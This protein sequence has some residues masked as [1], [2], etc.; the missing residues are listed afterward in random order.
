MPALWIG[1]T[2]DPNLSER[3]QAHPQWI[4]TEKPEW[5][6]RWWVDPSHRGVT[7]E[8]IPEIFRQIIDWGFQAVKWDCLP[9]SLRVMDEF[10]HKF[11]DPT[12]SSEQA[13]RGVVKAGRATLGDER[14]MMSCSGN[15]YRDITFAAD[16][17]DGARIGGDVFS[18][19]DYRREA[20]ERAFQY[21]CFH[22][23]LF[24][25]DQ[26]NLVLRG[27]YNTVDQAISRVSFAALTGTPLTFGD[28]LPSLEPERVELLKRA[29]PPLALHP[30]DLGAGATQGSLVLVNATVAQRFETWNVID[31]FNTIGE[32]HLAQLDLWRDLGLETGPGISY[33]VYDFWPQRFLGQIESYLELELPPFASSVLSV[34]RATGIP[35]MFSTSRHIFQGVPDL[36]EIFW[37]EPNRTIR[38]RSEVVAG[39]PYT[40]SIFAPPGFAAADFATDVGGS[41]R[42]KTAG[43]FGL[44][45][46][47][48]HPR[49]SPGACILEVD[50]C[51]WTARGSSSR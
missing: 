40:I 22:S 12:M 14:Y 20:V 5:C 19:D 1:A 34:R 6:G 42:A 38:G 48:L 31:V 29:L 30:L 7:G 35:Q 39:H 16:C 23:I 25:A 44:S 2:N 3:L 15:F 24:Y 33:L 10:H 36:R 50:S 43:W 18:W 27:E 47:R 32:R 45:V 4:L 41:C 46:L 17:F 11:S 9:I 49:Q 21:E 8:Y 28:D 37:D 51:L 26:D 13:L